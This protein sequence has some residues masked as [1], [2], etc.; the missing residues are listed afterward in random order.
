VSL[1]LLKFLDQ[2][3]QQQQQQQQQQLCPYDRPSFL[4]YVLKE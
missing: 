4:H 2:N 3:Q 1:L